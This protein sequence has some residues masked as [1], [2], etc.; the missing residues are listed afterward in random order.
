MIAFGTMSIIVL[1][2]ML[3]YELIN[4]SGCPLAAIHAIPRVYLLITS[5]SCAS[6]SDNVPDAFNCGGGA[7]IAAIFFLFF[8]TKKLPKKP[9]P[10]SGGI[11][12]LADLG[13]IADAGRGLPVLGSTCVGFAA[14]CRS[15]TIAMAYTHKPSERPA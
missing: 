6:F 10:E 1:R 12:G 2:M 4:S 3:K 9:E 5:T 15:L 8:D 11:S 13:G 14:L 7:S